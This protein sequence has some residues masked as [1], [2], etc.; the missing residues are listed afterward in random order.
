MHQVSRCHCCNSITITPKLSGLKQE[1]KRSTTPTKLISC[2]TLYAFLA[3][4]SNIIQANPIPSKVSAMLKADN[5]APDRKLGQPPHQPVHNSNLVNGIN[6]VSD[7][8]GE[9]Y[10]DGCFLFCLSLWVIKMGSLNLQINIDRPI[11]AEELISTW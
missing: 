2:P 6:M 9:T 11:K 10:I 1:A 8:P 3:M 7:H 5:L 4:C